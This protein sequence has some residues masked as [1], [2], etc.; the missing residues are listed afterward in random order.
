MSV[1]GTHSQYNCPNTQSEQKV[2]ASSRKT[3]QK[4]TQKTKQKTNKNPEKNKNE[5]KTLKQQQ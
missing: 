2:A 5:N 1:K 3:K 4:A